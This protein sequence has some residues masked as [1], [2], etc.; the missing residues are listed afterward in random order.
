MSPKP[1][2]PMAPLHRTTRQDIWALSFWVLLRELFWLTGVAIG[3]RLTAA[4]DITIPTRLP[5]VALIMAT[6]I[7]TARLIMTIIRELT[8]GMEVLM[9]RTD[10]RVGGPVTILTR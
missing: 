2:I 4:E 1:L 3:G 10:R 5:I 8:D 6:G 9:V 7:T